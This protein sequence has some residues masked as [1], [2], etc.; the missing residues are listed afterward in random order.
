MVEAKENR[1]DN[2][3]LVVKTKP[4]AEKKLAQQLNAA[5]YEAFA[6][7]YTTLRQWSDRKK[8]VELP[9]ISGVI[10]IK[11]TDQ[12]VG[13]LYQFPH[14]TGILKEYNRPALVTQSEINNLKILAKGNYQDEI[15]NQAMSDFDVG[16]TVQVKRGEFAGI[17][18][19]LVA[20]NGK[21]RLVVQLRT[22][23]ME[24]VIN[25]AKANVEVVETKQV[26]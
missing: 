6:P 5:G 4:R 20:V 2:T 13:A 9:L 3:W 8:K 21:H 22:L 1:V 24:L 16:V 15:E 17:V 25:I 23:H 7:T 11:N 12:N 19:E 26:A 10:F 14:V 18:G